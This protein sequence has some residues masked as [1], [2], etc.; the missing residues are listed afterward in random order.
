MKN[1]K[2]KIGIILLLSIFSMSLVAQSNDVTLPKAGMRDTLVERLVRENITEYHGI[3]KEIVIEA[4]TW[5]VI[6]GD[7]KY[8]S[9]FGRYVDTTGKCWL[10]EYRVEARYNPQTN[11]FDTPYC[12]GNGYGQGIEMKCD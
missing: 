11:K 12:R 3:A 6:P 2:T 10:I 4:K 7:Y 5:T 9:V 1:V 8:V